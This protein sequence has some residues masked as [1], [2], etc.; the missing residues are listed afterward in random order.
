MGINVHRIQVLLHP[1]ISSLSGEQRICMI[2]VG[3]DLNNGANS[4]S[5]EGSSP[6]QIQNTFRKKSLW[7]KSSAQITKCTRLSPTWRK[8]KKS[9]VLDYPLL[10]SS[11]INLGSELVPME[12]IEVLCFSSSDVKKTKT[13]TY[14][15]CILIND[16]I[17]K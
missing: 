9:P 7:P 12:T 8:S 15:E 10:L 3:E 2:L 16:F 11:G 5:T 6:V 13:D 4:I 14:S 17:P 1:R